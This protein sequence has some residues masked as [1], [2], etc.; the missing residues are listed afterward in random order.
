[1]FT[2]TIDKQV[3]DGW[4]INYSI[5][6]FYKGNIDVLIIENAD[7]NMI[8]QIGTLEEQDLYGKTEVPIGTDNKDEDHC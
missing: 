1:M 5:E 8:H 4:N 6:Q 7:E 3:S 2:K